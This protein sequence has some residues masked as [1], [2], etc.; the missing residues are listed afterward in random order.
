M[1]AEEMMPLR[2]QYARLW[3]E[4]ASKAGAEHEVRPC[5]MCMGNLKGVVPQL[6]KM[7]VRI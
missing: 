1:L 6:N 5:S 3:Y 2:L 4:C 7:Y